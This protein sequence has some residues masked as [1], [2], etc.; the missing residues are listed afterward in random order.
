MHLL[1]FFKLKIRMNY[2]GSTGHPP[3]PQRPSYPGIEISNVKEGET[4]HQVY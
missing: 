1:P 2:Q 3:I 4:V